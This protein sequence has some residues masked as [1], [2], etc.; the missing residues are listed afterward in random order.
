MATAIAVLVAAAPTAAVP[1]GTPGEIAFRSDKTGFP[2]IYLTNADGTGVVDLTK[3]K[4]WNDQAAWSP[5]GTKIV[6]TSQRDGRNQTYVMNADGSN[7]HN[8]SN[9]PTNDEVPDWSPASAQIAFRP[10]FS[11]WNTH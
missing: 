10:S 3:Q 8:I 11:T 1:R 6:F 9:S 7:Q 4:N 5:D 2:N